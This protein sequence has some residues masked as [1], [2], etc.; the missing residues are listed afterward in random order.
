MFLNIVNQPGDRDA[1]IVEYC[2][3]HQKLLGK[4]KERLTYILG[5]CRKLEKCKSGPAPDKISMALPQ[6]PNDVDMLFKNNPCTL[7]KSCSTA[8]VTNHSSKWLHISHLG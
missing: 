6:N 8:T 3:L 1:E 2:C 5:P 7:I 4:C